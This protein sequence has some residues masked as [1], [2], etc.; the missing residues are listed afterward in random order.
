MRFFIESL[1][2]LFISNFPYFLAVLVFC[3]I[4]CFAGMAFLLYGSKKIYYKVLAV[5]PGFFEESP[6]I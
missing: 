6:R 3:I 5:Q 4:F 2:K 1:E